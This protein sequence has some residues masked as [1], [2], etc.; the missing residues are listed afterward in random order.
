MPNLIVAEK[1]NDLINF[2]LVFFN[3]MKFGL[4]AALLVL[5]AGVPIV[6]LLS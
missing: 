6:V 2:H 1:A 5:V 4:P 3:Y